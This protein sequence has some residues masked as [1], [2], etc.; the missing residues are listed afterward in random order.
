MVCSAFLTALIVLD[1]Q[2]K[3]T[4]NITP[5]ILLKVT[6]KKVMS[7]VLVS[8]FELVMSNNQWFI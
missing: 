2:R 4:L 6:D 3:L 1:T 5:I 8:Y 7:S